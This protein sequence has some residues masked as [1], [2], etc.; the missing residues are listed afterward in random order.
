MT[1]VVVG[2]AALV[3][4]YGICLSL[5]RHVRA[6]REGGVLHDGRPDSRIGVNYCHRCKTSTLPNYGECGACGGEYAR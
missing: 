6:A 2:I 5:Y 4:G 1:P 3:A